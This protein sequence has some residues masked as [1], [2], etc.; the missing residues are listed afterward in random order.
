M[1]GNFRSILCICFLSIFA[2]ATWSA[3]A[4]ARTRQERIQQ[5]AWTDLPGQK[6]YLD[7]SSP[8]SVT[9]LVAGNGAPLRV[10]ANLWMPKHA[11][12]P[13]PVVVL[14]NCGNTMVYRKE[15]Y[16]AETFHRQ[17]YA[18]LIVNSLKARSPGNNLTGE[19]FRYRYATMVDVFAALKFLA[20]DRRIDAKRIAVMGWS[21]GGM[22]ALE[23]AI[24]EL[25]TRYAGPELHY[26]AI[27]A[28]SP[29][30]GIATLGRRFSGTPILSLHGERDD[31]MPL[32]PCQFYRQEAVSRG[33]NF[34]MIVYP[35]VFHNWELTYPVHRDRTQSTMGDCFTVTDLAQ[36]A[37]RLGDG[38]T[39]ALGTPDISGIL[40]KYARGCRKIGITEGN[41]KRS[42]TDS[43]AR[44][45]AFI[46]KSFAS[47]R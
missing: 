8:L 26:A 34:D 16:W 41:D 18:V 3:E 14:F 32:K 23:A 43:Y 45:S 30:C 12:G 33:A 22:A 7:T 19:V 21:N 38:T 40:K 28:I 37:M 47:A 5:N 39:V 36:R 31:S 6:V 13:V 42:R 27:V 35:G 24:E 1:V 25:R 44:I 2:F 10:E 4:G 46:E 17:G 29:N 9:Q 20:A 11:K 15:G